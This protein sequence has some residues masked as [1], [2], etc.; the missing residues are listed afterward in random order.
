MMEDT[1]IE[2]NTARVE[3]A[4]G[5]M[6]YGQIEDIRHRASANV[7]AVESEAGRVSGGDNAVSILM[8]AGI[9]ALMPGYKMFKDGAQ[10]GL[11]RMED[12]QSRG[13]APVTM[14]EH[15]RGSFT[16]RGGGENLISRINI[17]ASSLT[18]NAA[19][20]KAT[21]GLF[22]GGKKNAANIPTDDKAAAA[23]S[24]SQNK[25]VAARHIHKMAL[26]SVG[27]AHLQRSAAMYHAQQMSPR[28]GLGGGPS[29]PTRHVLSDAERYRDEGQA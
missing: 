25:V 5:D 24:H 15:I 22:G 20:D 7:Q 9:D 4:T 27:P 2:Q 1:L 8:D 29:A 23:V 19:G 16:G 17:A 26:D 6:S 18:N 21:D 3:Q 28:M 11:Q 14:D 10:L 12:I 13:P